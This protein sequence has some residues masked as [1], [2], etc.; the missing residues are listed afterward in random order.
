MGDMGLSFLPAAQ[1]GSN[2]QQQPQVEP[3]QEA[4]KFLSLRI[5][6]VLGGNAFA[7]APLLNATGAQGNPFAQNAFGQTQQTVANPLAAALAGAPPAM[8]PVSPNIS[9]AA[10]STPSLGSGI[11]PHILAAVLQILASG[12]R[13]QSPS[14]RLIPADEQRFPT[15][16]PDATAPIVGIPGPEPRYPGLPRLDDPINPAFTPAQ[17]PYDRTPAAG[18]SVV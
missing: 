17:P 4:V 2:P 3:T 7:P 11:P 16:I 1:P 9:G 10:P 15:P 6:K 13:G 12:N 14:P 5:P 18:K 8:A